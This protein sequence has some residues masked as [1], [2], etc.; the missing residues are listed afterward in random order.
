M[1][2]DVP[3]L[4]GEDLA[5]IM[6]T[7]FWKDPRSAR[8]YVGLLSEVVGDEFALAVQAKLPEMASG[9]SKSKGALGLGRWAFEL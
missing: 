3:A 6:L 7:G 8:H 1:Y 2:L 5:D 4:Q 9:L